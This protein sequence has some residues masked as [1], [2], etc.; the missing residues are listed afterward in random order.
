MAKVIWMGSEHAY[1]INTQPCSKIISWPIK[2]FTNDDND[3][4]S[5]FNDAFALG[6]FV[7]T[8]VPT[9]SLQFIG[10]TSVGCTQF[11]RSLP[12]TCW[13]SCL[14]SIHVLSVLIRKTNF[15][16]Q[17]DTP[18]CSYGTAVQTQ[19]SGVMRAVSWQC[20]G[21]ISDCWKESC[22]SNTVEHWWLLKLLKRVV[23]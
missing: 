21:S 3:S 11:S 16:K 6:V 8:V 18:C 19:L 10:I 17:V 2:T 23:S 9:G 7:L 20:S 12:T 4:Q 14:V 1:T 5:L 13:D 15:F 22:R